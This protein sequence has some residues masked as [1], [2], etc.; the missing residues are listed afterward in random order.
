VIDEIVS[1]PASIDAERSLLGSVLL[2]SELLDQANSLDPSAFFLSSH[3]QIF[4]TLRRLAKEG[5]AID[6]STLIDG[7][8]EDKA[9]SSVGGRPYIFSLTEGVPRSRNVAAYVDIISGKWQKRRLATICE[10][11]AARASADSDEGAVELV[12][13]AD[14]ALLGIV[15]DTQSEWPSLELQTHNELAIMRDQRDGKQPM[16]YSYGI[17]ALD[18]MIIGLVPKEMT[19]LGGRPQ[20]GKSSLIAQLVAQH[21]PNGVPAHVFSYEMSSGQFLRRIWSIV[22]GVPFNRVRHP[23][24]M[25]KSEAARVDAA[26]LR[27]SNWPLVIDES[28]SL[29]ADQLCARARM[30]KRKQ[31]TVVVCVDYLQKMRFSD[32]QAQRYMDVTAACVSMASLAKDEGFALLLLSSVSEKSGSNRNSPPTLQDFR[33]SGDIAYEASTAIL[34]HREID[35]ETER[36]M[37]DGM[38]IVAKA[39]SDSGGAVQIWFNTDTLTFES[40]VKGRL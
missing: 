39:R 14:R 33:Q 40:G 8:V 12:A 3:Q 9:L 38:I 2:N 6:I 23:D 35:E 5:T 26:S 34:I 7:L 13:E 27:V 4:R 21:C 24:R 17:P 1:A 11:Y 30:S 31:G 37:Q 36:P 18:R 16:G 22:S 32:K 15:A 29:T 28:S 10:N 20:Q 19:V 25:D